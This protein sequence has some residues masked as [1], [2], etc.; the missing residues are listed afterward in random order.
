MKPQAANNVFRD[1]NGYDLLRPDF[2]NIKG[3]V[4]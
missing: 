3:H 2:K 1:M 4:S